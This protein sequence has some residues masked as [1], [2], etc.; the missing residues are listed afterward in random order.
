MLIAGL[1][2]SPIMMAQTNHLS[3]DSHMEDNNTEAPAIHDR[4]VASLPP[5]A[6]KHFDKRYHGHSLTNWFIYESGVIAKFEVGGLRHTS[7]YGSDGVWKHTVIYYPAE[8]LA[9]EIRNMIRKK[10]PGYEI[11]RGFEIH[12]KSAKPRTVVHVENDMELKEVA[13]HGKRLTVLKSLQT[14]ASPTVYLEK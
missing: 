10:Y 4:R 14:S 8:R 6:K 2:I 9:E 12:V 11:R 13:V 3:F 5:L 7:L 1:A